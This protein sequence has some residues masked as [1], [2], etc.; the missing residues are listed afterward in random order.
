MEAKHGHLVFKRNGEIKHEPFL[1]LKRDGNHVAMSKKERK[2]HAKIIG[3]WIRESEGFVIEGLGETASSKTREE[4]VET[5]KEKI[6][7]KKKVR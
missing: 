3:T 2:I 4:A 1:F 5:W 6:Y 7:S